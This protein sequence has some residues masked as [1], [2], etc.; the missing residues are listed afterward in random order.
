MTNNLV[1]Q[2]LKKGLY[3]KVVGR[4]ILHYK[5]LSSTMDKAAE[6]A[7][8]GTI[9]GTVILCDRQRDGRGR[10]SRSWISPAGNL[11]LSVVLYPALEALSYISI[12]AGLAVARTIEKE[13]NLDP[14]IKWPN[15]VMVGGKKLCGLLV[16]NTLE[17]NIVSHSVVGIGINVTLDPGQIPEIAD[18]ATSLLLET[19]RE[20]DTS[21]LLLR[22][23]HELD[24]LY[25]DLGKGQSPVEEW[26]RYLDTLGKRVQVQWGA[27]TIAGLAEGVDHMG[28]LLLRQDD[29]SMD[30]LPAGEVTL[31]TK[32]RQPA[33]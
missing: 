19:G 7:R 21:K 18:I 5:E 6:E 4:R 11:T 2:A 13:T 12:I 16:E 29:G 33:G 10:F 22:L 8:T 14:T 32:S 30:V 27:E 26:S 20:P 23:L 31:K 28:H 24:E 25:V 1:P 9:E 3:T 17:G 15:D